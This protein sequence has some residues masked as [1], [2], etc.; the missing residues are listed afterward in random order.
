MVSVISDCKRHYSTFIQNKNGALCSECVEVV[1]VSKELNL[2]GVT[3][4]TVT[5]SKGSDCCHILRYWVRA[6]TYELAFG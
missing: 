6:S 5:K 3:V 2:K 1:P 4:A